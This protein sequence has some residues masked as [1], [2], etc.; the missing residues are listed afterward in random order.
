MRKGVKRPDLQ[1]ARIAMCPIC[2]NL[3]RAVKDCKN[4]KQKYCCLECW[5]KSRENPIVDIVCPICHKIFQ[6]RIGRK[7]YCSHECYA[8]YLKTANKGENSHWWLGGKTKE[9][10]IIRTSAKY[11]QHREAVLERDGHKCTRCGTTKN[12]EIHHIHEFCEY[13]ELVFEMNNTITLCHNCHKKTDNYGYKARWKVKE[14]V[15]K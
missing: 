14:K 3:F 13:P 12:L 5:Y 15:N 6:E 10:Q 7:K 1:R 11:R 8:E 9:K 2:K 4:R